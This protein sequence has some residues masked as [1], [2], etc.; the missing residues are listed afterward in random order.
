[1]TWFLFL[2]LLNVEG[3]PIDVQKLFYSDHDGNLVNFKSYEAC[4]V[5]GEIKA[6]QLSGQRDVAVPVCVKLKK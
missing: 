5:W 1:M 6:G 3:D 4:M 2:I